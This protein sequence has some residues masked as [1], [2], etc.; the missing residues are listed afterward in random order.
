MENEI[1]KIRLREECSPLLNYSRTNDVYSG[2]TGNH[3]IF[4]SGLARYG[5]AMKLIK[6]F[7]NMCAPDYIR[8][9][10]SLNILPTL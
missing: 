2:G 5:I 8:N 6:H 1:N 4:H 3:L 7:A 10:P 9:C